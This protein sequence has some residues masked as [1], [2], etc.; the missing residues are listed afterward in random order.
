MLLWWLMLLLCW[1]RRAGGVPRERGHR[2]GTWRDSGLHPALLEIN[3][4]KRLSCFPSPKIAF[5]YFWV[6]WL[7]NP[8]YTQSVVNLEGNYTGIFFLSYVFRADSARAEQGLG[9]AE[10]C[11]LLLFHL[12]LLSGEE[13][14]NK[15]VI[16][17]S[18]GKLLTFFL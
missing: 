7:L 4:E 2:A 15:K 8:Y 18:L 12:G 11:S 1:V 16:H 5:S 3:L 17:F 14:G 9:L 10:C 13:T 6:L